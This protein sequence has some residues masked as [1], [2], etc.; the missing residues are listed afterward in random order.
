[1]I[2]LHWQ[3]SAHLSSQLVRA[4][5]NMFIE[6]TAQLARDQTVQWNLSIVVTACRHLQ[7]QL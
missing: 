5:Q 4:K 2:G 7:V 3:H 1:M 6:V